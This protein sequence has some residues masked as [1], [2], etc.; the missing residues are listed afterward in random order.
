MDDP[1]GGMALLRGLTGMR[2]GATY[3]VSRWLFLRALGL[4][5]LI[6]FLSLWVQVQGLIG[7]EG[8]LP[9]GAFLS[10]VGEQLGAERFWLV[11]TVFWVGAGRVALHLG[12]GAGVLAALALI[13]DFRP[14]AA[15]LLCW[16]LYLS[17]VVVGQDFLAFQW[18]SLLLEAGL[19]AVLLA[20]GPRARPREPTPVLGLVLLW[21]LLFRLLFESGVG[22]LASGDP[23]WRSLT[24]LDYHFLTQPL[25]T[26]TAWYA[27]LLP[28][29]AKAAAVA[30]TFGLEL[31]TPWLIFFGRWPRRGALI[32]VL[33]LQGMIGG[34]GNYTFFNLLTGTLG[35]LLLDDADW[36]RLLP[37]RLVARIEAAPDGGAPG[38][39]VRSIRSACGTALLVLAAGSLWET[40]LSRP[41]LPGMREALSLVAPLESVN[42]YGLFRVMTTQRPE[43]VVQGSDDGVVWKDYGFRYKPGD[44][45]RRPSFVEPHQPRLDWQ[46]WFAALGDFRSTPWFQEFMI[47]LLD[48]S[49]E[50]LG[51]LARNPFPTHPPRYVRAELFD[52]RFSTPAERKATG[53]WW[54]R[55]AAGSYSPV[56]SF[57]PRSS[58]GPVSP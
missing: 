50:V 39:V 37:G 30:C 28:G 15:L 25:P 48:G 43:I 11:P 33:A 40:V 34:T 24:A 6:A 47:R 38:R 57:T 9:A 31:G 19:L 10:A 54:V 52:Y 29:W 17:L 49:P 21:F 8:I 3:E 20:P 2:G 46:M 58:P 7:P 42:S 18:D 35:L 16:A 45:G 44:V 32:G 14:R 4:V 1:A 56:L 53:A 51:L 22:K 13:L 26:W 27:N 36:R 23:T 5:F 55:T 12:E 41:V